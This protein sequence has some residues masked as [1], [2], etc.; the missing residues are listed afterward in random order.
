MPEI[1][2]GNGKLR[3]DAQIRR[4]FSATDVWMGKRA[5]FSGTNSQSKTQSRILQTSKVIPLERYVNKTKKWQDNFLPFSLYF[6]NWKKTTTTFKTAAVWLNDRISQI[7]K[8]WLWDV[9]F[10]DRLRCHV[11]WVIKDSCKTWQN[12]ISAGGKNHAYNLATVG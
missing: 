6:E 4:R 8:S 2:L 11:R 12:I 9:A 7:E 5:G 10:R 3:E 1:T